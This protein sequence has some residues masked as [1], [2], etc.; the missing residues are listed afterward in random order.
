MTFDK[1][2]NFCCMIFALDY[3]CC[4]DV[5]KVKS[6]VFVKSCKNFNQI[7]NFF[8]VYKIFLF[9][10]LKTRAN[11]M[12]PFGNVTTHN[13]YCIVMLAVK[14]YII[15]EEPYVSPSVWISYHVY[16]DI[17]YGFARQNIDSEVFETIS[18]FFLLLC[19]C[20]MFAMVI[21]CVWNT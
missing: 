13:I 10:T 15:Y 11:F 20:L 3:V 19:C 17:G 7:M 21:L 18:L 1:I 6:M 12:K 4:C 16:C 14:V 2:M 9:I 5:Q 8:M